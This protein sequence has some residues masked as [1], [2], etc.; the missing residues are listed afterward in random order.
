M[1][2]ARSNALFLDTVCASKRARWHLRLLAL[3]TESCS[4][5]IC[6]SYIEFGFRPGGFW[7]IIS[8]IQQRTSWSLS[9]L[10]YVL[11][12]ASVLFISYMLPH[13]KKDSR[14]LAE[15]QP[16]EANKS[17]R[18]SVPNP[19]LKVLITPE[20]VGFK[21]GCGHL[22]SQSGEESGLSK[23]VIRSNKYS[24]SKATSPVQEK[25]KVFTLY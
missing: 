13:S 6:C 18:N 5:G 10:C 4:P 16:I 22:S 20:E 23:L 25:C 21:F 15:L 12:S 2:H 8:D 11:G 14:Q 17:C 1:G 9:S 3:P 24:S 19:G 7:H